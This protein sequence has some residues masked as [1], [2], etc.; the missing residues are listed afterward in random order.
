MF[1]TLS[2][3]YVF[4]SCLAFGGVSGSLFS[5]T[6]LLK[7]K[8]DTKIIKAII[9]VFCCVIITFLYLLYSFYMKFPSLRLYMI[10]G[11]VFGICLYIKSFHIILAKLCKKLYNILK[12][13][14][15]KKI[16]VRKFARKD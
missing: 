12:K 8:I 1:V 13:S 5:I 15:E 14:K 6:F 7:C 16:N 2:Q 11:V 10:V 4:L 3:F 9:D